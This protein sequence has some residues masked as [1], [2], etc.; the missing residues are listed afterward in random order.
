M[1]GLGSFSGENRS[2]LI[3]LPAWAAITGTI[4]VATAAAAVCQT[5]SSIPIPIVTVIP[6][7]VVF[8][9]CVH[10]A[11]VRSTSWASGVLR[12]GHFLIPAGST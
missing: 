1:S 11:L 6:V 7:I 3:Y 12:A 2:S 4:F 9:L 10:R 5:R 8:I